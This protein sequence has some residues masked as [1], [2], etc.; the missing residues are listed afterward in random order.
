MLA[1]ASCHFFTLP[2]IPSFWPLAKEE[3]AVKEQG[4][5]EREIAE[6]KGYLIPSELKNF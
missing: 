2:V 3:E 1:W 5:R 4:E 6:N